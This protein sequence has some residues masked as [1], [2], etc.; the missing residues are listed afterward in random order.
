MKKKQ[1]LIVED[2]RIVAEDIKISLQKL[3]YSVPGTAISGE[4]AVKKAEDMQP[5][6]V[7]MD[8][9]LAGEMDG[10][11]A[12]AL[13]RS[14]FEI[15][16]VYL[17]ACSDQKTL[18]KVIITD[19]FG[20]IIKPYEDKDLQTTIEMALY[21]QKMESI[22]KEREKILRKNLVETVK[23]LALAVEKR[24][25]Y[26]TSHQRK[27]SN[28][29]CNIAEEMGLP[30]EQVDGLRMAGSVHD[31]G[32]IQILTEILIKPDNLSQ[33]E[34]YMIK[35]HPQFGYDILRAIEFPYPV[36]QI[37]LQHHERMDGSG[38]P[39]SLS[40]EDILPEARI[41]AVADVVEAMSTPRP[42]RPALGIN[43]ALGE[44]SKDKGILYDPEAVDAC[45]KL[46]HEKKVKLE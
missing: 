41:L 37:V 8:I 31:V 10:I 40:G 44:I 24:D 30:E 19:P 9:I 4:E 25:I 14:R 5:D 7:L 17:T 20:Y 6:L 38:Y 26:T 22:L 43:K 18:N 13:I 21:K 2:E 27:V 16:V 29:A 35:L 45:L 3:G 34:S 23:A 1:I 28:L 42:H 46:F 12:S 33:F 15:P 39:E 11:E 36:A 32:T